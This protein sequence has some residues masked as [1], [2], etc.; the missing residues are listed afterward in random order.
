M[1]LPSE[2]GSMSFLLRVDDRITLWD[3]V[4]RVLRVR[5]KSFVLRGTSLQGR[6]QQRISLANIARYHVFNSL[7]LSSLN[8]HEK[9]F[10]LDK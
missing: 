2:R 9:K 1:F 10:K 6:R 7:H 4:S 8:S 5:D 3:F